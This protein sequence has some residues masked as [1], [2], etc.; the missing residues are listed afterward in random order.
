MRFERKQPKIKAM[1]DFGEV[2]FLEMN[3]VAPLKGGQKLH[4]NIVEVAKIERKLNSSTGGEIQNR[5]HI[6]RFR[7]HHQRGNFY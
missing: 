1:Q 5:N 6:L 7:A 2:L 4:S 3:V